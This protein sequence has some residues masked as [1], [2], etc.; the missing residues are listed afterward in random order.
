MDISNNITKFYPISYNK[1]VKKDMA[2]IMVYFNATRSVRIA[3]HILLVKQYLDNAKIPYYI[4]ELSI[5]G[6]PYLFE[7]SSNIFHYKTN[8]YMFY[9]ENLINLVEARIPDEYTK[10]CNIDADIF[11]SNP[12]WYNMLSD[13]LDSVNICQPFNRAYWLNI[14][15]NDSILTRQNCL[16]DKE[17]GHTG[18]VWAFTRQF[19]K[20]CRLPDFCVTGSGDMC[21]Y[22][23]IVNNVGLTN[24]I[25][26]YLVPSM[27]NYVKSFNILAKDS[28]III[29]FG[30]V[31]QY[32]YHLYHGSRDNRKYEN[33]HLTIMNTL[34]KLNVVSIDYVIDYDSN[35]LRCWKPLYKEEMNKHIKKYLCDRNDDGI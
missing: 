3:Q 29:N 34:K 14:E 9:K 24:P 11:F 17:D 10:I 30:Y 16:M 15:N 1:P 23:L 20:L 6:T 4:G 32:V 25:F 26:S 28:N 22:R 2:I 35:G 18:F 13:I 7:E 33:R 21:F 19:F 12:D 5:C 8:D 27:N 31:N